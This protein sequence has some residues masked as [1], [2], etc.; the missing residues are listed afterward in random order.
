MTW[1]SPPPNDDTPRA[2]APNVC[3]NLS[4]SAE[5][6]LL[7]RETLTGLAE[8]VGLHD[9]DL[10]DIRT[11]VTEACNNVVLHAYQ[12]RE[13]PMEVEM[14]VPRHAVDVV[15]RDH[16][17][18]IR[19]RIPN[20][21]NGAS[22]IGVPVIQALAQSVEFSSVES[23]GTGVWMRFATP[24]TVALE[25]IPEQAPELPA[26]VQAELA[27]TLGIA[28]APMSLA[29]AILPRLLCVLAA[30]AHFSTDRISDAQLLADALMAQTP[31]SIDGNHLGIG[32]SVQPR[33][34]ELHVGPLRT[35]RVIWRTV[36][37]TVAGLSPV[38]EKVVS[39]LGV[40][41]VGSSEALSLRL[42]A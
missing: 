20:A 7:V 16:G 19:P 13:G 11:A 30:R 27:R 36:D 21:H 28:I 15:V 2:N 37:C 4:N 17:S 5:N 42:S 24:R 39:D 34:L 12:G 6:V 8:A 29:R 40:V 22:G 33:N 3:L 35:G 32:V 18:G 9:G 23:E 25:S 10:N 26:V 14:Y 38:V 1:S 31:A 41:A